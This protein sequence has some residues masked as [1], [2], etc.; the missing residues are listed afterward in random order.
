MKIAYSLLFFATCFFVSCK[1]NSRPRSTTIQNIY[2]F[3]DLTWSDEFN[4]KSIDSSKWVYRA[5]GSQRGY[6]RV[7][8]QT[9][10]L[11]GKGNLSIK[12][13]KDTDGR[14]Y[15][16]QLS[17][18]GKYETA[19]GYFEC[20]AKM[21]T[22][23]GPHCAFWLQSPTM[24]MTNDKPDVNGAEIDI[25]EYHRTTPKTI[26]YGIHWNGYGAEMRSVSSDLFTNEIETG[27]HTFGLEWTPT[28]YVYFFDGVEMG[29]IE[30]AISKRTQ[31]IILSME[32]T[33]GGGQPSEG[34]FPDSVSF[35]YVKVYK[36]R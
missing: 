19:F 5:E 13:L 22:Q 10:S 25:F 32:L 18:M 20:K 3:Y 33:G 36:K 34:N 24:S 35:D 1:K 4:G 11:D 29:R 23:I 12:V 17:S 26:Y 15:V 27:Y 8:R 21:H 9:I 7:S 6:A 16:G 2:P 31:Y 14:Y 30:N 28:E